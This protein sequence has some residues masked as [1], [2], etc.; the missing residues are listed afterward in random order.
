MTTSDHQRWPGAQ[1]L[2]ALYGAVTCITVPQ[3]LAQF[4]V[5]AIGVAGKA[6]CGHRHT[7]TRTHIAV[8]AHS[9]YSSTGQ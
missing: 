8:G 2:N 7:D 5:K 1:M 9:D 3:M 6:V 4:D